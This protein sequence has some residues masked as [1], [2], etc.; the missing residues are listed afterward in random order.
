MITAI[1]MAVSSMDR[2][3]L[4]CLFTFFFK[5]LLF[6]SFFC[7]CIYDYMKW[8]IRQLLSTDVCDVISCCPSLHRA[9]I[10]I[11][12]IHKLSRLIEVKMRFSPWCTPAAKVP[13][14]GQRP[15]YRPT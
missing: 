10:S 4:S 14:K 1:C 12:T 6:S 11:Y 5:I 15:S 3:I 13:A 9:Y 7:L 8:M 2:A